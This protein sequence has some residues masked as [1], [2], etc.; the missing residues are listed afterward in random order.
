MKAEEQFI[1]K[2]EA[3]FNEEYNDFTKKKIIGMLKD[4]YQSSTPM[5]KIIRQKV[6]RKRIQ[7]TQQEEHP[8]KYKAAVTSE[9]LISEL[10]DFC[11]EVDIPVKY[12]TSKTNYMPKSEITALRAK[13]CLKMLEKYLVSN[14]QL[15]ELFSVHVTTINFYIYGKKTVSKS[16][17]TYE[18]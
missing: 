17:K 3:Y 12:L 13:F 7:E 1:K 2:L 9:M 4:Y 11:V 15:C 5:V 8:Q 18:Y 16:G 10:E 14:R 6:E